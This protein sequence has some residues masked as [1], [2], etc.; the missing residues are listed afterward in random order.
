[1]ATLPEHT[2]AAAGFVD[3]A[4]I[5]VTEV[6]HQAR[7]PGFIMGNEQEVK[8]VGYHGIGMQLNPVSAQ[9]PAEAI[10]IEVVIIVSEEAGV[11]IVSAL[12]KMDRDIGQ[13]YP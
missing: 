10:E 3:L 2:A 6:L 4:D 1:M 5:L 7:N 13:I 12:E 9:L 8:M 11:P